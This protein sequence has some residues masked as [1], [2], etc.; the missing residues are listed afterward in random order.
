MFSPTSAEI[1]LRRATETD[2]PVIRRMV[3]CECLNPRDVHWQN[4]LIAE[5]DE[6]IVG[7]GQIRLHGTIK[8]LGSLVVAP[9]VRGQGVGAALVRAL[10]ARAGLPLYLMCGAHN[11]G[12][13]TR[14][15][16]RDLPDR[17][18]PAVMLPPRPLLWLVERVLRMRIHIMVKE[19]NGTAKARRTRSTVPFSSRPPRLL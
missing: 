2:Q 12:Y 8:E 19:E 6:R 9:E 14:L 18:R 1:T 3:T 17:E 4:F 10:E 15:G 13:Y 5:Q 16:Y 11:V 7:I